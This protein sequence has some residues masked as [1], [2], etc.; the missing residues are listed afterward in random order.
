MLAPPKVPAPHGARIVVL[1]AAGFVGSACVRFL[2]GQGVATVSLGRAQLDLLAADAPE[3]LAR[4]LRPGDTLLF[5]SADAPCKDEAMYQTNLRMAEVVCA[6]ARQVGLGHVVYVSSDAVYSDSLKPLGEWSPTEPDSVHGRMHLARERLLQSGYGGPLAILRPTL[7]Y[8]LSDPHD[9]YGPNRFRRRAA[10]G[11]DIVLFGNG[12]ERRDHIHIDDVAAV[13]GLVARA[14]STGT[15]N[16][17]TGDV[18]S[19]RELAELTADQFSPQV[20]VDPSPRTGPMP[21]GGYRAFDVSALR[22][23]LPSVRIVPWREGVV[24]VC[25]QEKAR[26]TP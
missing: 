20:R 17:A 23:S 13:I 26:P 1:G 16:V 8:G 9:G 24:S 10:A 22:A 18:A 14:G 2:Q 5:I 11:K 25:N 15:L 19:F 4:F 6:A 7:I 3:A 12:E 21:H